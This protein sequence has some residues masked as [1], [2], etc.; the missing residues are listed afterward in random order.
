MATVDLPTG[1]LGLIAFGLLLLALRWAFGTQ[2]GSRADSRADGDA[3]AG[4]RA[5]GAGRGRGRR[6]GGRRGGRGRGRRSDPG[7]RSG[8]GLLVPVVTVAHEADAIVL[9][10]VLRRHGIRSTA[11][12]MPAGPLRV[13][14]DGRVLGQ[15]AG[16][17]RVLVFPEDAASARRVV[18]APHN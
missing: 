11:A 15:E 13:S 10:S 7:G 12:P 16:G 14:A 5:A 9:G 8:Y 4:G 6:G 18:T 17:W 1:L 3:A 2:S